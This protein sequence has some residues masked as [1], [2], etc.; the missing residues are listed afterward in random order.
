MYFKELV[1]QT[2]LE[3]SLKDGDIVLKTDKATARME[4][5]GDCC[6]SSGTTATATTGRA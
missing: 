5:I 6:S 3:I 4:A 1:G 2:L